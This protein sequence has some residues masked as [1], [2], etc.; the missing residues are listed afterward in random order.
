MWFWFLYSKSIQSNITKHRSH[1]SNK[2]CEILDFETLITKLYLS[3]K[4]SDE[5]LYVLKK[6]GDM[7]RAPHQYIW[8]ENRAA[9]IWN[10]AMN[11]IGD[12]AR[13]RNWME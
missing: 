6:F 13:A 8:R 11:I 2:V 10:D 3:G 5:H 4:L 1:T 9:R 12:A 7:R